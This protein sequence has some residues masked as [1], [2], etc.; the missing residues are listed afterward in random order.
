MNQEAHW[1]TIAPHYDDEVFDVFKSDKKNLLATYF[2]RYANKKHTAIDFGCGT[3][4]ALPY[5][6][7][8]FKQVLA[9]DISEACM[10]NAKLRGYKNVTFKQQ[11]LTVKKLKLPLT[12][13][14]FCCNVAILPEIEKNVA[15][16]TNIA[17][18]LRQ[19]GSALFIIPS[20]DSMMLYAWRLMDWYRKEGIPPAHVPDHELSY[21]DGDKKNLLQGL[22][23][24]DGVPTKHYTQSEIEILFRDAGFSIEQIDR[25]EYDWSTEFLSPPAWMKAPY[26]WDWLVACKKK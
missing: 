12:D 10:E 2:K 3:G 23:S 25:V 24:I 7:P 16:I 8:A 11:D 20:L 6:S 19:G 22:I 9:V 4:K 15:I 26:P 21:F 14:A 1:N 18:T 5:L 17:K 13:F